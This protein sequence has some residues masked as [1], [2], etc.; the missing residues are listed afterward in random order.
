MGEKEKDPCK[1]LLEDTIVKLEEK[2]EH[3]GGVY[4]YVILS[5]GQP[6]IKSLFYQF[7]SIKFLLIQASS[8]NCLAEL[9]Y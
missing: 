6:V 3:L 1:S 2:I 8:K 4:R 9:S 5:S 7:L